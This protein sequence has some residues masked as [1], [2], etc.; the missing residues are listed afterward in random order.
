MSGKES[1]MYEWMLKK[2]GEAGLK[3]QKDQ[4][5]KAWLLIGAV[6]VGTLLVVWLPVVIAA[7]HAT[8]S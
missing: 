2:D 4:D 5:V 8:H 6:F 1:A 3:G 7:M